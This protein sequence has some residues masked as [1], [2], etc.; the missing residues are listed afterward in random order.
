[1]KKQ[2]Q[3]APKMWMIFPGGFPITCTCGSDC[4]LGIAASMFDLLTLLPSLPQQAGGGPFSKNA[5][6]ECPAHRWSLGKPQGGQELILD[7][8]AVARCTSTFSDWLMNRS[9]SPPN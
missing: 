2:M 1:M 9:W 6:V 4:F 7:S 3:C 5:A 8:S